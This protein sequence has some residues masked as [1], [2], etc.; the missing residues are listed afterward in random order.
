VV[1]SV[2]G[3]LIEEKKPNVFGVGALMEEFSWVLVIGKLSLF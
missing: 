3:L 2:D 1:T